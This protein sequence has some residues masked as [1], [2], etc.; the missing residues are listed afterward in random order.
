MEVQKE[1]LQRTLEEKRKEL[2][3]LQEK[4]DTYSFA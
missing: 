4:F 1:D 3:A 2:E